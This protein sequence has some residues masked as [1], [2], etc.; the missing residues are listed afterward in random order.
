[1]ARAKTDQTGPRRSTLV[2]ERARRTRHEIVRAALAL[3]NERG[4]EEGIAETT[5]EE[6]AQAAGVAKATFYFHFAHKEE[7][8]L[9][10]GL[11]TAEAMMKDAEAGMRKG[12]PALD[13]L[14]GLM[15][16]LARRVE[17]A[18]PAAVIRSISELSRRAY[19]LD[20][21]PSGATS[22]STAFAAVAAYGV[23]RGEL[24]QEIDPQ[25]F[26]AVL[27]AITMDTVVRWAQKSVGSLRSALDLHTDLV[28][29]GASAVYAPGSSRPVRRAA[30]G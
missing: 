11:E 28:V 16:T 23:Q 7:I 9:E 21:L 29:E 8:L 3:W 30:G 18:P 12:R 4:F 10:M 26:G 14:H 2:Q 17:R 27:Q 19:D 15:A 1:M 20:E 24:A 6:I 5:V 25:N 13:I 22:F